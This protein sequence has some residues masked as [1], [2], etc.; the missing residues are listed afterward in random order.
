[1]HGLLW[2]C[3]LILNVFL[4]EMATETCRVLPFHTHTQEIKSTR[5]KT[6]THSRIEKFTYTHT[7]VSIFSR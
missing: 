6:R 1:M 5:H 2:C 4:L 3:H 7:R